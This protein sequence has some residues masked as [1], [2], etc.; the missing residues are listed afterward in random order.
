MSIS[1]VTVSPVTPISTPAIAAMEDGP[2]LTTHQKVGTAL[3]VVA[4]ARDI[5][6]CAGAG[7]GIGATKLF[8]AFA[9]P[10]ALSTIAS[11][12]GTLISGAPKEEF[13]LAAVGLGDALGSAV[14]AVSSTAIGVYHV[15]D[16]AKGAW[17]SILGSIAAMFGIFGTMASGL[18]FYFTRR[19]TNRIDELLKENDPVKIEAYLQELKEK[20]NSFLSR[21]FNLRS[22]GPEKV[23]A[24]IE[25]ALERSDEERV[26]LLKTLEGRAIKK[27][28]ADARDLVIGAIAFI[29]FLALSFNPIGWAIYTVSIAAGVLYLANLA[30]RIKVS[31]EP[32]MQM[33]QR[34]DNEH[35]Y[36]P[37]K[38]IL[39]LNADHASMG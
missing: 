7:S 28:N 15:I 24:L 6:S 33:K 37:R 29:A 9:F 38:Y 2:V 26:D 30:Y 19:V 22:S 35:L 32:L 4:V 13:A 23:K 12:A 27:K 5:A 39:N 34:V 8:N 16:T 36:I 25:K 11:Q 21:H 3:D 18:S 1:S 31:G 14:S 20:E 17:V 10:I